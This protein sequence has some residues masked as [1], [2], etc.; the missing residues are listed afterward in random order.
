MANE[1]LLRETDKI[2]FEEIIMHNVGIKIRAKIFKAE[3]WVK[4]MNKLMS[5]RD[6]SSGLKFSIEWRSIPASNEEELDTKELVDILKSDADMLKKEVFDKVVNHFRSKVERA[7][8][9]MEEKTI[10]KL[11]TRL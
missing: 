2:L 10:Q 1:S 6:T 8:R 9:A 3:E 7:R 5:E 11:F 4:K